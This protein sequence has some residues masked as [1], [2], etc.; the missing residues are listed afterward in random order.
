MFFR[1]AGFD[2]VDAARNQTLVLGCTENRRS[3]AIDV[4][5]RSHGLAGHRYAC[6][7]QHWHAA[8]SLLVCGLARRV[9]RPKLHRRPQQALTPKW[10]LLATICAS[11]SAGNSLSHDPRHL[12]HSI[13]SGIAVDCRVACFSHPAPHEAKR[14]LILIY[15]RNPPRMDRRSSLA[16]RQLSS[17]IIASYHTDEL[18]A[19]R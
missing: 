8:L 1:E 14:L 11:Q 2:A 6:P 15:K 13:D 19:I 3:T 16:L 7:S 5:R 4:A 18:L 10:T 17:R 9:K 12:G